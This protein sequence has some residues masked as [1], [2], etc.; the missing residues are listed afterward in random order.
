MQSLSLAV[1]ASAAA[2]APPGAVPSLGTESWYADY[3]LRFR[4]EDVGAEPVPWRISA[5]QF[6]ENI[7]D[8]H[9]AGRPPLN[10]AH[11]LV[12]TLPDETQQQILQECPGLLWTATLLVAEA[13]LSAGACLEADSL[14]QRLQG[15]MSQSDEPSWSSSEAMWTSQIAHLAP[16]WGL[17]ASA[18]RFR[19]ARH[20]CPDQTAN[21]RA[22]LRR[23]EAAKLDVVV[24]FCREDLSWLVDFADARL[25]LYSKCPEPD[26]TG[27]EKLGLPCVTLEQLPNL[28]MESLAYAAHLERRHGGYADYTM[29][30][31]GEPFQHAPRPLLGDIL[32]AIHAGIYNVPFLHL[33]VR[34]FLAGSSLCLRDLY[35]RLFESEVPEVF[36]SYCCSQFVVRSDRLHRSRTFYQR[37]NSIL[38]G[39]MPL[40]CAQDV[41]YDPRPGI[42]ISALFEHLWHVIFGEPAVLSVRRSNRELPLF[43]Q[44]D[45]GEGELPDFFA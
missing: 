10:A 8:F 42:A 5:W 28:G 19:E 36:G 18:H 3:E 21:P 1:L 9:R 43:A 35:M 2:E 4:P 14:V 44:L 15:W 27:L 45:V 22:V 29:F 6:Q 39:E 40:A 32:A 38:L 17:E 33:N 26:L 31:Q 30:L 20:L 13:R 16:G 34:R 7:L 41:K 23:C 24:A 12:M 37:I 25:W 11:F